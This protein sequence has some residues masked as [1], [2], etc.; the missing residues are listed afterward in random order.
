MIGN[1]NTGS[2]PGDIPASFDTYPP[3]WVK[4]DVKGPPETGKQVKY[5]QPLVKP[6]GN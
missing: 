3:E 1:N 2:S 6:T 4:P 5:H